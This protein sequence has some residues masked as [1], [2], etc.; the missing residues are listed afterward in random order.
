MLTLL[1]R[2]KSLATQ[3]AVEEGLGLGPGPEIRNPG[4]ALGVSD[5]ITA[6]C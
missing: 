4:F 3:L 1:E 6:S 5:V 2:C